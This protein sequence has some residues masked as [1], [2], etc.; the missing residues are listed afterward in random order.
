MPHKCIHMHIYEEFTIW[1]RIQ[2]YKGLHKCLWTL[3]DPNMYM[4]HVDTFSYYSLCFF[5]FSYFLPKRHYHPL[6]HWQ[7][8]DRLSTLPQHH[9]WLHPLYI[10]LFIPYSPVICKDFFP[11]VYMYKLSTMLYSTSIWV[12][13]SLRQPFSKSW[14]WLH[15]KPSSFWLILPVTSWSYH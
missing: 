12:L 6:Y 11:L 5:F 7:S 14:N 10:L 2:A 1:S 9:V 4:H 8:Y 15:Y 13:Y 3:V